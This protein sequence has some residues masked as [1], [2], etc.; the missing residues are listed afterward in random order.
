MGRRLGC[1]AQSGA[2][3]PSA[4]QRAP[5][6]LTVKAHGRPGLWSLPGSRPTPMLGA[7]DLLSI[8]PWFV[9]RQPWLPPSPQPLVLRPSVPWV[10]GLGCGWGMGYAFHVHAGRTA[11]GTRAAGSRGW[12]GAVIS[13]RGGVRPWVLWPPCVQPYPARSQEAQAGMRGICQ[14]GGL[15]QGLQPR[16]PVSL[17]MAFG[18]GSGDAVPRK[19]LRGSC[20]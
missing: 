1:E 18:E 13:G 7:Q 8:G 15:L 19:Q 2:P 20:P 3:C 10:P 5:P 11:L 16:P 12:G 6:A 14:A 17:Q 4:E 9:G